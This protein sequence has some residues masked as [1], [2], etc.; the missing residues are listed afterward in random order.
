MGDAYVMGHVFGRLIVF[1]LDGTLIDSSRDLA[2][3]VNDL[4]VELDAASLRQDVITR[5]IG[6][7]ARVLLRRALAAARLPDTQDA[8]T[9]FLEIYDTRLL[10]H[11]R[12]Y[13]G[14]ADIV[15]GAREHARVAVLT[16][17]PLRP[18]ERVLEGLGLRDL[19]DDVIGGDGPFPRKPDPAG[20]RALMERA[21]V[22]P[23]HTLMV[24]DSRVDYETAAAASARCCLVAYGFSHHTLEGVDTGE[25][26]VVP[27]ATR[28]A[29]VI[30][31][32][33][34]EQ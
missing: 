27:D 29:E 10:N 31:R 2:D 18:S 4:L 22:T 12:P 19:F 26:W 11:T 30:G 21:G 14:I 28:L 17:K 34:S 23:V 25:A 6:D 20:L 16:N 15:R 33:L 24:G 5:M 9:R 13:D 32:F 8:M 1:D 3:S 7:G